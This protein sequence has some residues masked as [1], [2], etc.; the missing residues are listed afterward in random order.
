PMDAPH[1]DAYH[2]TLQCLETGG[3]M[4]GLILCGSLSA[5]LL[6]L[7]ANNVNA[8]FEVR[9]VFVGGMLLAVLIG[10]LEALQLLLPY[11]R[12]KQRLTHGSAMWAD[13][14]W[15]KAEGFARDFNA[16]L[17]PA[18]LRLGTLPTGHQLVLP[19]SHTMRHIGMFGPP[20]SGKSATFIST[21]LRNWAT[22]GSTIVLDPKGE[23][24]EQTAS[25]YRH[26]YRLDLMDPSHS[27]YWN[28]LP[29]CKANAELA[30]QIAS[31]IVGLKPNSGATDSD[32][33]WRDSEIAA[34]T[35]ILL[36]LPQIVKHPT[37]AMINEFISVR[38]IDPPEGQ[39]ESPLTKE[40][41]ESPDPQVE[42]YWGAFT[43]AKRDLQ[44]S[45]LTGVIAKCQ[46]FTTPNVKAVTSSFATA[47]SDPRA[48]ID[49]NMLRDTGT[50]IYVV[51]PEGDADRYSSFITTFFGLAMTILRTLP[52]TAETVPALFVFDEAGNIPI[53]GLKEML[54]VGRGRKVGVVLAYQN[55]GQV[56]T[57]YGRDGGDAVLGSINTMV[58]LPGLD[59]RT[60][61]FAAKRV[62]RTTVLQHTTIDAVGVQND[63]ERLAETR[64]DLIDAAELRQL[65]RHKQAVAIIDT[66]PPIKFA[67][68]PFVQAAP[69][70]VSHAGYKGTPY[71][72]DLR[73]AE[74]DSKGSAAPV[75]P[76]VA[77]GNGR[78]KPVRRDRVAAPRP[79][80]DEP[81]VGESPGDDE[82][83]LFDFDSLE[84]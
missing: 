16:G 27:D 4:L 21:F 42:L 33:F 45:I 75:K 23:L 20:G 9:L 49:L 39:T 44:G 80:S 76:R 28:F 61:E 32:T 6:W 8:E 72:I 63:A 1:L 55:I 40:M 13:T 56:Y 81:V 12:F 70:A 25:H 52:V 57:Q 83:S 48:A 14:S 79:Q 77:A 11:Y 10:C 24:F 34:L 73:K 30:H 50:A 3:G 29:D 60:T 59:Q 65:V 78:I 31:I 67:Y 41:I 54:G 7:T 68:P 36:H 5:Y 26:V 66:A 38:S 37:P 82:Q 69:E 64:R 2:A 18:E 71:V 53:H 62:G 46:S 35:A 74:K 47:G 58:F 17:M 19:A 15:L 51:I 43:K 22:S 84:N